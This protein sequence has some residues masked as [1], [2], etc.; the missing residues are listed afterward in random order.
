MIIL[1]C[2]FNKYAPELLPLIADQVRNVFKD[3]RVLVIPTDV[4]FIANLTTEQI[5][6]LKNIFEQELEERKANDL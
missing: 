4:N 6:A 3:E 5:E 1:Q 2:D